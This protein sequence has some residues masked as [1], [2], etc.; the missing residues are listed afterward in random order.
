[1]P[2]A[3]GIFSAAPCSSL[4][5]PCSLSLSLFVQFL[6]KPTLVELGDETR[7]DKLFRLM[8][9]NIRS[10]L[11]DVIVGRFQTFGDRVG[12]S[13]EILL[14][15]SIRA[16][17]KFR[18]GGSYVLGQDFQAELFIL[19]VKRDPFDVRTH[20]AHHGVAIFTNGFAPGDDGR[21]RKGDFLSGIDQHTD[22][23]F[24]PPGRRRDRRHRRRRWRR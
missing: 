16:F 19:F 21:G 18:V 8:A 2:F 12:R 11:G 5:A 4:R 17:E 9:A 10:C 1:M 3:L 15:D 13:D 20:K 6:D 22:I 23:L 7:V 14:E 24:V